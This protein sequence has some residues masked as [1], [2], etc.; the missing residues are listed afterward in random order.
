MPTALGRSEPERNGDGV[1]PAMKKFGP[2]MS[3]GVV[4]AVVLFLTL[5]TAVGFWFRSGLRADGA[6]AQG[7]EVVVDALSGAIASAEERL[8]AAAGLLRA[9]DLV[10]E[11]ELPCL[12]P[13]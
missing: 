7:G 9:S 8:V 3:V 4:A 12:Q 5:V 10:S 11:E 2:A 13:M 1:V 6:L